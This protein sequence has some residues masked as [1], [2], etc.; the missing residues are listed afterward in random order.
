MEFV[1]DDD[2]EVVLGV[3]QERVNA[4]DNSEF[5]HLNQIFIQLWWSDSARNHVNSRLDTI[6]GDESQLW[7]YDILHTRWLHISGSNVLCGTSSIQ[8][9][10]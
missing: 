6:S 7:Y 9:I 3:S 1:L 2:D 4:D 8:D 5:R 10:I